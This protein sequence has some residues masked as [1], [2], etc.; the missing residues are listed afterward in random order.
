M[1]VPLAMKVRPFQVD[2]SQFGVADLDAGRITSGVKFGFDRE[3]LVG[4]GGGDQIDD[5]LVTEERSPAPILRD[6]T[7]H[8]MF[9]LVPLART[10][11]EVTDVNRQAQVGGQVLQGH[12]PQP[13]ATPITPAAIRCDQQF[14]C[15]LV[16]VP[17]HLAPPPPDGLGGEARRI[18]ID[19]HADP[20]L[21]LSQIV[22]PIGNRFPQL[23]VGKVMHQNVDRLPARL[24]FA[25]GRPEV[26]DQFFL[27]GVHRNRGLTTLLKVL[28]LS[29]EMFKL[30][31]PI[32]VIRTFLRFAIALQTVAH[33]MQQASH[34]AGT[35][36]MTLGRQRARQFSGT[37]AEPAQGRL[38]IAARHWFDQ[39]FQGRRQAR[40]PFSL[41]F[42]SAAFLPDASRGHAIRLTRDQFRQTFPNRVDRQARGGVDSPQATP[43]IRLRFRRR[44]FSPQAF[45]H[46][47]RQR[48]I[49]DFHSIDR[50]GILHAWLKPL[51]EKCVNLF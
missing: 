9:N 1:I 6:M 13:T 5:D 30:R 50:S 47:W 38:R 36:G 12:F 43:P 22:D 16:T 2:G 14:P 37:F 3:T 29:I 40:I 33:G 26:P 25:P 51:R 10:G 15:V 39:L 7:E 31:I 46:Q 17:A 32:W 48:L 49:N 35:D 42:A 45:I 8:A 11:R 21:I 23:R 44:P 27:L 18:V 34:R 28:H 19:A 20:A 41:A 4:R 24:P